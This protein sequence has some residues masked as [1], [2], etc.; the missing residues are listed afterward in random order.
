M[1]VNII[2]Q[3]KFGGCDKTSIPTYV[4]FRHVYMKAEQ[5]FKTPEPLN[6]VVVVSCERTWWLCVLERNKSCT[7][8]LRSLSLHLLCAR[9]YSRHWGDSAERYWNGTCPLRAYIP[10]KEEQ[11]DVNNVDAAKEIKQNE[12][13]SDTMGSNGM[14]EVRWLL[15]TGWS[16][17]SLH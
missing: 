2:L 12:L 1:N 17:E 16:K 5:Q 15:I 14:V 8:S 11:N 3:N 7:H 4:A 6:V 9:H 13:S 10:V